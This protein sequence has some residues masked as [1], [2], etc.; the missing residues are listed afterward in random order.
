MRIGIDARFLTH[1]QI[2]GF[3]TY[4]ENLVK[5][6][7]RV[8]SSNTYVLYTDRPHGDSP[9]PQRSNLSYR[10]VQGTLPLLGMPF[11]EQ[12]SLPRHVSR[13]GIDVMH[14]PCL[15]AP[16]TT[17]CRSVVTVHDTIWLSFQPGTLSSRDVRS[18]KRWA[19][20]LY[21]RWVSQWAA[22]RAD[23]IIAVSHATKA[24]I[25]SQLGI[26][27]HKISVVHNAIKTIFQ[28]NVSETQAESVRRQYDLDEPFILGMGSADPRKNMMGL[29]S[30]YARLPREHR[31]RYQLVVIWTHS[32]LQ[33]EL[34]SRIGQLG[35][36]DRV[37]FLKH[38]PDRDLALIYNQASLFVFPSHYEGFGLPPLEAMACG[39]PVVAADNSSI[40]EVVGEAGIVADSEDFGALALAMARVLDDPALQVELVRKGLE[41]ARHFSWERFGRQ[42]LEVYE[43]AKEPRGPYEA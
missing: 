27:A 10:V 3:R 15:T 25:V 1:P 19:M 41:R 32:L 22:E 18:A 39:T 43:L 29:V 21:N 9:L 17:R 6:L 14:S 38:V 2:G 37:R 20:W 4:T 30:A 36:H 33:N 8:D 34:L 42:T 12:I 24:D 35:I 7:C 26:P 31:S 23:H 28:P 16:L 5:A 40:P 13:D 11:R